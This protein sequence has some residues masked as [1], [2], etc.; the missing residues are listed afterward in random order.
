MGAG[1]LIE[2]LVLYPEGVLNDS[3]VLSLRDMSYVAHAMPSHQSLH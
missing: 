1:N 2:S 3:T